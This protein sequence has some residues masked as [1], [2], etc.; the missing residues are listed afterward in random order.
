MINYKIS[1]IVPLYNA[2]NFLK[3][4]FNSVLNQTLGFD[5]IELIL[6]DDVSTDSTRDI[7]FSL[8][9]K[10]E[11]V[12]CIFLDENSGS[13]CIP[14]NKG[15]EEANGNYIMFLDQD[16]TYD[17]NICKILYDKIAKINKNVV[18]C[19][20]KPFRLD[21]NYELPQ[22]L[23]EIEVNPLN[24]SYFYDND[25]N[26]FMVWD[27]IYKR[28]FIIENNIKFPETLAEDVVFNGQVF[29]HTNMIL[30]NNYYGYNY[31]I[32]N[33]EGNRSVT[34]TYRKDRILQL[35]EGHKLFY[36]IVSENNNKNL[37]F[38]MSSFFTSIFGRFSLMEEKEYSD[39]IDLLNEFYDFEK[40]M[41]CGIIFKDKWASIFNK[42]LMKRRFSL[43]IYYSKI[44]SF[45][46]RLITIFNKNYGHKV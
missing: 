11:N 1:V 5:N 27:K 4:A 42:L 32:R 44:L 12:K 13:P 31:N 40:S 16:D 17:E 29:V 33:D 41:D 35:F 46:F 22:N 18:G 43:I 15:I 28:D 6:V 39:K 45:G 10:Y 21:N 8:S 7:M 2:E 9:N 24:D 25:F 23:E 30:I 3:R 34:N 26:W 38:L 37:P 20:Y 36:Y 14:R 19:R